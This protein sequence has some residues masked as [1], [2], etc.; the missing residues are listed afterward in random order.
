LGNRIPYDLLRKLKR[1][2]LLKRGWMPGEIKKNEKITMVD[3]IE[4]D[5]IENT[6][7]ISSSQDNIFIR[8]WQWICSVIQKILGIKKEK[9]GG[10]N[11]A[12]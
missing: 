1:R 7:A 6:V 3:I 2:K 9:Q 10:K 4:D 5:V 12:I 8:F 11:E